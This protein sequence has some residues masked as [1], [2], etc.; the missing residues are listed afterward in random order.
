MSARSYTHVYFLSSNASNYP[1]NRLAWEKYFRAKAISDDTYD[2]DE[3]SLSNQKIASIKSIPEEVGRPHDGQ[4][5][6]S[7]VGGRAV[8]TESS[9]MTH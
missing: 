3:A 6:R 8:A 2:D 7:H 5:A 1:R 9:Q 4:I